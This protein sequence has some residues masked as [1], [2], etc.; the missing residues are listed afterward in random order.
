MVEKV[1]DPRRKKRDEGGSFPLLSTYILILSFQLPG[2]SSPHTKLSMRMFAK[3]KSHRLWTFPGQLL[4]RA[5]FL[6]QA[7]LSRYFE[8]FHGYQCWF[9][10]IFNFLM[11][12]HF[13]LMFC[14]HFVV[15][16]SFIVFLWQ[17]DLKKKKICVAWKGK[18]IQSMPKTQFVVIYAN[19][20]LLGLWN[21]K[22]FS[23]K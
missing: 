10:L 6:A 12:E 11:Y 22:E 21:V 7:L 18:W 17:E 2:L 8:Y 5:Q 1:G 16:L 23:L 19:S 14:K 4:V 13:E 9:F 3:V 15:F 20:L